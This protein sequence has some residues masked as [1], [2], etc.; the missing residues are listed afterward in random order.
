MTSIKPALVGFLGG[1]PFLSSYRQMAIMKTKAGEH[2]AA[3]EWCRRGM[4]I[5]GREAIET[6]GT[7]DLS[8]RIEKLAAKLSRGQRG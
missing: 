5:Y 4:A 2:E 8:G 7:T 1:V 3:L 6:E